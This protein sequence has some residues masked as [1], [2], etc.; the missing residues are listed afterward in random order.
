MGLMLNLRIRRISDLV[1]MLASAVNSLYVAPSSMYRRRSQV[2]TGSHSCSDNLSIQSDVDIDAR[3][4]IDFFKPS[5]FARCWTDLV[6]RPSNILAMLSAFIDQKLSRITLSSWA[7]HDLPDM[8]IIVHRPSRITQK[9]SGVVYDLAVE[10]DHSFIAG[11]VVVHN[12]T[13][14]PVVKGFPPVKWETGQDWLLKQSPATQRSIMGPGRFKAWQEGRIDLPAMVTVRRNSIWGDSVQPTPLRDLVGGERRPPSVTPPPVQPP[15]VPAP[16][17]QPV[18][19]VFD[20]NDPVQVRQRIAQTER[21]SAQRMDE[22]EGK[23]IGTAQEMQALEKKIGNLTASYEKRKGTEQAAQVLAALEK[24]RQDFASKSAEQQRNF[25]EQKQVTLERDRRLRELV[26]V[27]NPGRLAIQARGVD[28]SILQNWQD[29]IGDFNRLVSSQVIG[30]NNSVAFELIQ[31]NGRAFFDPL[32]KSVNVTSASSRDTVVHE[33]GHWLEEINPDVHRK[34]LEFYDRRT[35]GYALEWLGPG[36]DQHERTRR[37]KF[38]DEYMG[39]D[40]RRQATELVS[41]GIEYLHTKPAT[42][43]RRDPDMFDWVFNLVR[44][45]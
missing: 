38:I 21:K 35:Q 42:L 17:P 10:D 14:I 24:A 41:M 1:L 9:Y 7:L 25:I 37:D 16:T 13:L 31:G 4:C 44:G 30:G 18:E 6:V 29:G 34:A 28:T 27:G 45:Q 22:I 43:A 20:R 23:I 19:P 33:L 5:A 3:S 26:G 11:G 36:Y 40:Y 12:C 8:G 32:P 15:E 39:K 2:A